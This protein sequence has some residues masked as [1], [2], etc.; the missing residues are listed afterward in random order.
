MAE[1]YWPLDELKAEKIISIGHRV[2]TF[3]LVFLFSINDL[4]VML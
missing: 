1:K 2:V 3:F 4:V